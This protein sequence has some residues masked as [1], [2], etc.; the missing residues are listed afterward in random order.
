MESNQMTAPAECMLCSKI[1]ELR[2]RF[3]L[4]DQTLGL[5][6]CKNCDLYFLSPRLIMSQD[7]AEELYGSHSRLMPLFHRFSA[8]IGKGDNLLAIYEKP[9]RKDAA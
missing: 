7:I 2:G 8:L 9:L 3:T 1:G 6:Y 4:T 5:A